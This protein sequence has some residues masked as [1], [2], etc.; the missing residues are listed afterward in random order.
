MRMMLLS[1]AAIAVL[2]SMPAQAAPLA[3][4]TDA[5]ASKANTNVEQVAS[6]RCWWEDGERY[7]RWVGRGVYGYRSYDSGTR[8]PESFRTGS[9][10]WW[11]AMDRDGRGGHNRP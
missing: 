3:N 4:A 9:S 7:C 5:F 11:R 6:R 1:G 10:A 8:R 2:F